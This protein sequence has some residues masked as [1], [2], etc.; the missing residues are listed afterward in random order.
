M[1][2]FLTG[3]QKRQQ[4]VGVQP[5][6]KAASCGETGG[7]DAL[8]KAICLQRERLHKRREQGRV[9]VCVCVGRPEQVLDSHR[10]QEGQGAKEWSKKRLLGIE[11]RSG[12]TGHAYR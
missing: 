12:W 4:C 2:S 1:K 11:V 10:C 6:D 5:E 7:W 9:C 3:C 8:P